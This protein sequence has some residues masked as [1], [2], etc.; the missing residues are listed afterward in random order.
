MGSL[1]GKV[2]H[3]E[4]VLTLKKHAIRQNWILSSPESR[5]RGFQVRWVRESF[6]SISLYNWN[7]QRAEKQKFRCVELWQPL[8]KVSSEI[9]RFMAWTRSHDLRSPLDVYQILV[10]F[11]VALAPDLIR[12]PCILILEVYL[13]EE[14]QGHWQ[15]IIDENTRRHDNSCLVRDFEGLKRS[16]VRLMSLT[17]RWKRRRCT[18]RYPPCYEDNQFHWRR[19]ENNLPY[20]ERTLIIYLRNKRHGE[21]QETHWP[22]TARVNGDIRHT[23]ARGRMN[24]EIKYLNTPHISCVISMRPPPS[25]VG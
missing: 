1:Q 13:V 9:E 4:S 3:K 21:I 10:T 22:H 18:S 15:A 24:I 17:A 8:C 14:L 19:M 20:S 16:T 11:T 25:R 7:E 5:F 6:T 23:P 2:P 12:V